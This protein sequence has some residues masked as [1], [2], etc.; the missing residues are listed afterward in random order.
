MG[1]WRCGEPDPHPQPIPKLGYKIHPHA[2]LD[3][4][5]N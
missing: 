2:H 5:S 1:G 3:P 4:Q